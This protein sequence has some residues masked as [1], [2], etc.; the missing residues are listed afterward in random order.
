MVSP[1]WAAASSSAVVTSGSVWIPWPTAGAPTKAVE[2]IKTFMMCDER[3][4]VLP[5]PAAMLR[6]L[7]DMWM[8][9]QKIP[10]CNRF[11]IRLAVCISRP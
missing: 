3:F 4:M 2:S 8:I 10:E 7:A 11:G 5:L 1:L 6:P 9:E